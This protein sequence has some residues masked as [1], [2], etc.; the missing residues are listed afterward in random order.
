MTYTIVLEQADDG[1]WGAMAPDIP[2]LLLLGDTPEEIIRDAPDIIADHLEAL[3]EHGHP[4]PEPGQFAVPI[5]VSSYRFQNGSR[6][7][8]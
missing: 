1:G 3:R 4:I 5:T 7:Y 6:R 2:G 8:G